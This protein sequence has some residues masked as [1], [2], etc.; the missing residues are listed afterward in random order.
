MWLRGATRPVFAL[1]VDDR[2][3]APGVEASQEYATWVEKGRLC[4]DIMDSGRACRIARAFPL[5]AAGTVDGSLFNGFVRTQHAD[6][7]VLTPDSPGVRE[8]RFTGEQ[9]EEVRNLSREDFWDR[10]GLLSGGGTG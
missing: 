5:D 4:V 1:R 9:F 3:I 2:I 7:R 8:I 6:V 10:A